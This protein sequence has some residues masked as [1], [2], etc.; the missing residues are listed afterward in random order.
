MK[1]VL[2]VGFLLCCLFV[3]LVLLSPTMAKDTYSEHSGPPSDSTFEHLAV[4][5]TDYTYTSIDSKTTQ[6]EVVIMGESCTNWRNVDQTGT[7]WPNPSNY[8]WHDQD[9]RAPFQFPYD[10]NVVTIKAV[11]MELR[12]FDIDASSEVD[13]V[14]LND[15]KIRTLDGADDTWVRNTFFLSF[16]V[17]VQGENCI[18]IDVDTTHTTK[19][20]ATTVDWIKVTIVYQLQPPLQP[21]Q[22]PPS[23]PQPVGGSWVPIN[24]FELLAPWITLALSITVGIA[25]S[26]VYVKHKNKQQN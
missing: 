14:H 13:I 22:P 6:L 7:G 12:V 15:V 26:I 8:N 1:K 10:P 19:Y 23:Q 18:D 4:Q 24:K 20:W 5:P 3:S 11:M 9:I 16:G 2:S 21:L 25:A 17:I